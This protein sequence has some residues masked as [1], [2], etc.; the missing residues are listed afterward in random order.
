MKAAHPF[1][2]Y[3][4]LPRRPK[5]REKTK[6]KATRAAPAAEV[7][8]AMKT[9]HHKNA[10]E[11]ERRLL[12]RMEQE[13][14]GPAVSFAHLLRSAEREGRAESPRPFNPPV[15][16]APS[17]GTRP[18]TSTARRIIALGAQARG[19]TLQEA[20]VEAQIHAQKDRDFGITP[21]VRALI[22]RA[23]TKLTRT[24]Q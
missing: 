2:I 24:K 17:D 20:D 4:G 16:V 3:M 13:D 15:P 5:R 21:E 6:A 19:E 11:I 18:L 9:K 23:E 12:A 1:A 8:K 10:K 14:I 22:N 7:K